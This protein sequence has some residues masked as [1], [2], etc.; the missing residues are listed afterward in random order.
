MLER[1]AL[2]MRTR[3]SCEVSQEAQADSGGYTGTGRGHRVTQGG[4]GGTGREITR[5]GKERAAYA[6][7]PEKRTQPPWGGANVRA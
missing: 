2:K 6:K 5:K 3:E 4:T 1:M 7:D